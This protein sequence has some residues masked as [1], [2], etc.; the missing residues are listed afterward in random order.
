M[1][2]TV[3]E[4]AASDA[5]RGTVLS[6]SGGDLDRFV[7]CYRR[8]APA[9]LRYLLRATGNERA[10][11]EDLTSDVFVSALR[12]WKDGNE[13]AGSE[14]SLFTAARNRLIDHLRRADREQRKLALVYASDDTISDRD[15]LGVEAASIL[16][17]A[18]ELPPLQRAVL[19]LRYV[20]DLPVEAIGQQLER[21]VDAV[22]ALLRRARCNLRALIDAETEDCQ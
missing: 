15:F 11:A 4:S 13:R 10:L 22:D 19:A 17:C 9:V 5:P 1:P 14:P 20:D 3:P 18:R 16:G 12:A 21:S 8:T 7:E 2:D 6:G